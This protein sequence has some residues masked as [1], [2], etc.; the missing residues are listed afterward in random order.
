MTIP[1]SEESSKWPALKQDLATLDTEITKK[2][3][4]L[5]T[6]ATRNK[7]LFLYSQALVVVAGV[8]M[9]GLGALR[10]ALGEDILWPVAAEAVLSFVIGVLVLLSREMSWQKQ[11][12]HRRVASE[13]LKTEFFYFLGRVDEYSEADDPVK[14][15]RQRVWQVERRLMQELTAQE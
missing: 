6:E 10:A 4:K 11:W 5:S 15:L 14:L 2:R 9:V 13:T 12:L 8:V 7:N 3:R 1:S